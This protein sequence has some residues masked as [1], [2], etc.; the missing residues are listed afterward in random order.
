LRTASKAGVSPLPELEALL[1]ELHA[2]LRDFST[3]G[4]DRG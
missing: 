4:G 1:V 2:L 3:L